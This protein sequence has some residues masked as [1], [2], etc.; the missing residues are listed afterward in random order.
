M[1]L[2][3]LLPS[4]AAAEL[5][6]ALPEVPVPPV[7]LSNRSPIMP[8]TLPS[9]TRPWPDKA[10]RI[11]ACSA[12]DVRTVTGKDAGS[13]SQVPLAALTVIVALPSRTGVTITVELP[14]DSGLT[15]ATAG[16]LEAKSHTISSALSAVNAGLPFLLPS[17]PPA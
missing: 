16:S 10:A 2:S 12:A 7:P 8:V 3:P 13:D 4:A 9:I 15:D 11:A 1:P 5:R 14:G 17:L 6:Q